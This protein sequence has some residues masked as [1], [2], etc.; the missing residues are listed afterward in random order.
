MWGIAMK[1]KVDKDKR[2]I[3]KYAMLSVVVM[4]ISSLIMLFFA[5]SFQEEQLFDR[6]VG[7]ITNFSQFHND[8]FF[9]GQNATTENF[10]PQYFYESNRYYSAIAL[11]D[12][13]GQL[14]H[15]NGTILAFFDENKMRYCYLDEFISKE[16]YNNILKLNDENDGNISC[17]SFKY[18]ENEN[19]EI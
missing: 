10:I 1:K 14:V 16:D 12:E 17:E 8:E 7:Q 18:Y 3:L 9:H 2:R 4:Y 5:I 13:N 15:T 6:E 11:Y 19:N